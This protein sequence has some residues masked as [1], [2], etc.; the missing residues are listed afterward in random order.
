MKKL[1]LT[2]LILLT[3]TCVAF[4]ADVVQSGNGYDNVLLT[5]KVATFTVTA[6]GS[7]NV[8]LFT[9]LK[10]EQIFGMYAF[11][12]E[13]SSATDDAFQ[14]LIYTNG[15]GVMFNHTTTAATT[16]EAV[17]SF[18]DRYLIYDAPKIDVVGL[19]ATEIAT[20]KVTFVR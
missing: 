9:F 11:T 14:V 12:V 18:P 20:I 2:L 7:G 10:P 17:K 1:L 16:G 15:G 19:T 5:G 13:M 4:G 6:D 8:A 3:F